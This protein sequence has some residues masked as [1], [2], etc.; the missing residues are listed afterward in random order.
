MLDHVLHLLS[1]SETHRE[2]RI[3]QITRCIIPPVNL[4]QYV[5]IVENGYL[6]AWCSWAFMDKESGD[7]FLNGDYSMQPD[8]WSSG[9]RLVFM[10]FVAPFGHTKKLTRIVKQ[11]FPNYKKAEWRRHLKQRRFGV[12]CNE[13]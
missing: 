3:N 8:R 10:D 9:D 1:Q 11:Q 13:F 7:K 2:W 12:A 6:V 5:G 4:N